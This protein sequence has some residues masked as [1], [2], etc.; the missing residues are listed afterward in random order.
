MPEW[1]TDLNLPL[2][3]K[4]YQ[5]RDL[6]REDKYIRIDS[7]AGNMFY[8]L[9]SDTIT[10]NTSVEDFIKNQL[11]TDESRLDI[12]IKNV[13]GSGELNFSNGASIDSA[14]IKEGIINIQIQN[15]GTSDIN[16]ELTLPGLLTLNGSNYRLSGSIKA[17]GTFTKDIDLSGYS[18]TNKQQTDKN[19]I[20]MICKVNSSNPNGTASVKLKIAQSKLKYISGILPAK[21]LESLNRAIELPVKDDIKRFRDKIQLNDAR[22]ILDAKYLSNHIEP[23]EITLK[24]VKIYGKRLDGSKIYLK[25]S[26]GSENLGD[27][28][29]SN[30][31]LYKEFSNSNSNIAEILSFLPDSLLLSGDI[32]MNPNVKHGIATDND[33]LSVKVYF[34]ATSSMNFDYISYGDTT[35]FEIAD[36]D[37]SRLRDANSA[38]LIYEITNSLP[39]DAALSINFTD[40]ALNIL[41]KKSLTISGAILTDD[42]GNTSPSF[43]KSEFVL[44][45]AEIRN[46]ALSEKV[47]FNIKVKTSGASGKVVLKP[48]SRLNILS[49]CEINYHLKTPNR[50]K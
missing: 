41:F 3:K 32:L 27:Y 42:L 31:K 43:I 21:L 38:R 37:R 15:N 39:L 33:S 18:F 22:L 24:N 20:K 49:Y 48:D 16:F 35:A 25:G 44:D 13:V 5:L 6:I 14:F 40:K 1:N 30:G 4:E 9:V 11:N 50:A 46:L 36:I 7:T 45:S 17:N 10:K 8:R 12:A 19:K 23:F 29:V 34:T 28:Y 2:T 26:D 47:I